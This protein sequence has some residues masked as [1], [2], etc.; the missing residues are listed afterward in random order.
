MRRQSPEAETSRQVVQRLE[1]ALAKEERSRRAAVTVSE[2]L[3]MRNEVLEGLVNKLAAELEDAESKASRDSEAK[4]EALEALVGSLMSELEQQEQRRSRER[5]RRSTEG[6]EAV[7][8]LASVKAAQDALVE[9]STA[10]VAA[11]EHTLRTVE[12]RLAAM[13]EQ[14]ERCAGALPISTSLEEDRILL[15]PSPAPVARELINDEEWAEP[16][17]G[18]LALDSLPLHMPSEARVAGGVTGG[19]YGIHGRR[20][21]VSTPAW[22][23]HPNTLQEAWWQ[24]LGEEE[25][26]EGRFERAETAAAVPT[27]V[28]RDAHAHAPR[29]PSPHGSVGAAAAAVGVAERAASYAA[30]V[31]RAIRVLDEGRVVLAGWE[32]DRTLEIST[33]I[34]ESGG[35]FSTEAAYQSQSLPSWSLKQ[36]LETAL[37]LPSARGG[38]GAP[39]H[40]P[41]TPKQ[42]HRSS[43]IAHHRA[44]LAGSLHA[45]I[46]KHP[47]FAALSPGLRREVARACMREVRVRSGTVVA[48]QGAECDAF[49][50]ISSGVFDGYIAEAGP[51]PVRH[52]ERGDSFGELGLVCS[53]THSITVRCREAGSLWVLRRAPFHFALL[54]TCQRRADSA[55]RALRR[56]G[57]LDALSDTQIALL[58]TALQEVDLPPAAA[59]LRRGEAWDAL[60]IVCAGT[61]EDRSAPSRK[62]RVKGFGG[63]ASSEAKVEKKLVRAGEALGEEALRDAMGALREHGA[64]ADRE[65][66]ASSVLQRRRSVQL[67]GGTEAAGTAGAA[68][69]AG[70]ASG[71]RV[72]IPEGVPPALAAVGRHDA[73][74]PPSPGGRESP[75]PSTLR[76]GFL[77]EAPLPAGAGADR[78]R[79]V[80]SGGVG[81]MDGAQMRVV[82]VVEGG[83]GARAEGSGCGGGGGSGGG[84]SGGGPFSTPSG[85]GGH[86][87]VA[88]CAG[89]HGCS[90]LRLPVAALF[91][92]LSGTAPPASDL[93][94]RGTAIL[95]KLAE[96]EPA[97]GAA[98]TSVAQRAQLLSVLEVLRPTPG[99]E[100]Q[101]KGDVSEGLLLLESGSIDRGTSRLG[102]HGRAT[103]A[104]KV[105]RMGNGVSVVVA[106]AQPGTHG[107]APAEDRAAA[108]AEGS[109]LL[110]FLGGLLGRSGSADA[111]ADAAADGTAAASSSAAADDAFTSPAEAGAAL[112]SLGDLPAQL[113]LYA[114]I[115]V[116]AYRLPRRAAHVILAPTHE[117]IKGVLTP[118]AAPYHLRRPPPPP[119]P[120]GALEVS[121]LLGD[122]AASKV[123]LV[124]KRRPSLPPLGAADGPP[125]RL[126]ADAAGGGR[127]SLGAQLG[128]ASPARR[129]RQEHALKVLAG[130]AHRAA[131]RAK[132]DVNDDDDDGAL[133]ST[134]AQQAI[135]ERH[136]LAACTHQFVPRLDGALDGYILME[137]VRG[138]ELFY[139]LR[140][141]HRFEP[142]TACFYVAMVVSALTH[143]HGHAIV[144]RDLKPENLVLDG[145]GY[146]R[147]VDYGHSR[148]LPSLAERAWTMGGTPEYMAPEVLRGVGHGRE[149]DSWAVGVLLFELLAGYPA[150]CADEPIKVFSLVLNASPSV[151]RSFPAAAK[152]LISQL[153]RPQPHSRLGAMRGGIVDVGCHAFFDGI[154]WLAL[155]SRKVEAPLIPVVAEVSATPAELEKLQAQLPS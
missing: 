24:E 155:L 78:E 118:R 86:G 149:V 107:G 36:T 136:A 65:D 49:A 120:L 43:A 62:V 42:L 7:V 113:A 121:A 93:A 153:L 126:S 10:L 52:Y 12:L 143:L 25:R 88:V 148:P 32:G 96:A 59:L 77:R 68:G 58:T 151:P 122:G 110:G 50:V 33:E 11:H 119:P 1:E 41:G 13:S 83:G 8:P 76:E 64:N 94:C 135:R 89:D 66:V 57:V 84:G 39:G 74:N 100:L 4:A 14:L 46:A 106:Q 114:H 103:N 144:Y 124:R 21:A 138:C 90:L 115:G 129:E 133:S 140:E 108:G 37:M 152:D 30:L 146:L 3:M 132:G 63:G 45:S 70:G 97:L 87:G 15:P 117:V 82:R 17:H 95:A 81:G 56:V 26:L 91:K 55:C 22:S 38:G 147:L 9:G 60:Y 47:I 19:A 28:A 85:V 101:R 127:G 51:T 137:A 54:S 44:A 80:G 20:P 79:P 40:A 141:V 99:T 104:G 69:A 48:A 92:A 2:T 67:D 109:G 5:R 23:A 31:A 154:D 6:S 98:F 145:E 61:L 131:K 75:Q 139:L 134:L 125:T 29:P 116:T 27:S 16:M 73:S 34:F 111:A 53:C 35:A 105:I 71:L 128:A 150:F 112:G 123:L 130:G 18:G 72:A 142:P 102:R